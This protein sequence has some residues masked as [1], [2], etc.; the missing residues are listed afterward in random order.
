MMQGW[1]CP[2]CGQV[3]GPFVMQCFTCRPKSAL[4]VNTLPWSPPVQPC[5]GCCP[6]P[7]WP[8]PL[9]VQ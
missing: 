4:A 8:V 6:L 3:Y 9:V 5:P 1:E 2:K 7:V